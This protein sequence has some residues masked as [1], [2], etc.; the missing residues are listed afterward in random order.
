MT[1]AEKIDLIIKE[2]GLSRRK[3]AIM[4]GIPPSTLQSAL[5]RNRNI[6]T[7][8]LEKIA[9]ALDVPFFSLMVPSM[10]DDTA[11]RLD[12]A[13]AQLPEE[14]YGEAERILEETIEEAEDAVYDAVNI[15]G[16]FDDLDEF[17]QKRTIACARAFAGY[18]PI[19]DDC[20]PHS[21]DI[22]ITALCKMND[23]GQ[24]LTAKYAE[25]LAADPVYQKENPP[26]DPEDK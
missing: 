13:F 4:A 8:M 5:E 18:D 25:S 12:K 20:P 14:L 6:A 19:E 22:A 24:R 7:E 10:R 16:Y 17:G 21:M 2:K 3:V 9:H 15:F 11:A 1:S 23:E 26:A